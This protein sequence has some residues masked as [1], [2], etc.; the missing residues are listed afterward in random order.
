MATQTESLIVELDANTQGYDTKM[1]GVEKTNTKVNKSVAGIGRSAGMAGI[2]LQQ[3]VGQIQGGQSAMLAL[4]QQSADLGF[5]LGAPLLGAVVGIS[6]SLAGILLPSLLDSETATDK[7]T[8]AI[9]SLNK[10]TTEQDGVKQFTK[11]IQELAQESEKAARLMVMVAQ[12]NVRDMAH[13]IGSGISEEFNEAFGITFLQRSFDA[14]VN[15]AGTAGAATRSITEDI[16]EIGESFGL[17]GVEAR[18]AGESVLIGIREMR[19]A[20]ATE[21]PDAKEKII[22]FQ[23]TLLE[24]AEKSDGEGKRKL[25]GFTNSISEYLSK[26]KNAAEVTELLNK[27]IADTGTIVE[28]VQKKSLADPILFTQSIAD[29]QII[30]Q[31]RAQL[32]A[33]EN[34]LANEADFQ[35]KLEELKLTGDESIEER[36]EREVELHRFM[37][38]RKLINEEQFAAAQKATVEA[39][40][41]GQDDESVAVKGSEKQKEKARRDGLRAASTI[42]N[43]AFEENKAI[44]AGVIVAET[45]QNVVTS[46]K[47]SGGVPWGLPAGAAALAMGA[48][49]LSALN[50]A[51]KGGGSMAG[52][53][54]ASVASQPPEQFQPETTSLDVSATDTETGTQRLVISLEDGTDL[55][56]GLAMALNE[57]ERQGR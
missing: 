33:H 32:E 41:K 5:V 16:E 53:G 43:A 8:K 49:Q 31:Q 44:G 6:A 3:F 29:P 55:M 7:L 18:K 42:A 30:A 50:S 46:V 51:S 15:I 47:N 57:N 9:S 26:A 13:A 17:A 23:E 25:L 40:K 1:K 27:A 36:F 21:S 39:F 12:Q 22:A 54:S 4:S 37:L 20:I 28:D 35:E 19:S 48:A 38:E 11:D 34:F 52:V 45:A 2:Q 10:I 56:S 24:L 14:L